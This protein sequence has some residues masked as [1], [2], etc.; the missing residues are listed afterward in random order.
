LTRAHT[1]PIPFVNSPVPITRSASVEGSIRSF[2]SVDDLGDDWNIDTLREMADVVR[3]ALRMGSIPIGEVEILSEILTVLL[4]DEQAMYNAV[5]L[6]LIA[7]TYFDKLLEA[8]ISKTTKDTDPRLQAIHT[9]ATSLQHR[10]QQRFKEKYF[11]IDDHRIND[12][13][14]RALRDLTPNL[15]L[16]INLE[17][18]KIGNQLWLVAKNE[19]I[20]HKEGDLGFEPGR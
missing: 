8:I 12:M 13:R 4:I 5:D 11:S 18:W 15:S 2:R 16:P 6:N 20:S 9:R 1:A 14:H 10:W 17:D 7:L 3:E 19:P